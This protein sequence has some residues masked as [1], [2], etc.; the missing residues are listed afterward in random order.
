MIFQQFVRKRSKYPLYILKF[1]GISQRIFLSFLENGVRKIIEEVA[2][3]VK[4][5][6]IRSNSEL[7]KTYLVE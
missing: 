1:P 4:V 6:K 5:R 2:K 3:K 7:E